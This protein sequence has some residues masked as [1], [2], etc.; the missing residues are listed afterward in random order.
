MNLGFCNRMRGDCDERRLRESEFFE[1]R[2]IL[3][4]QVFC[5]RGVRGRR[6]RPLSLC[7]RFRGVEGGERWEKILPSLRISNMKIASKCNASQIHHKFD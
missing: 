7:N 1:E 5:R 6:M 3:L 2:D 4:S